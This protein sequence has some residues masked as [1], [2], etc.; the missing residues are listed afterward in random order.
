MLL[1]IIGSIGQWVGMVAVAAGIAI[2][3]QLGADIGF[4]AITI[5]TV[6]YAVATKFV[7]L[8]WKAEVRKHGKPKGRS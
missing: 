2:E 1:Y 3:L 5:G 4:V 6:A 8:Y 7:E